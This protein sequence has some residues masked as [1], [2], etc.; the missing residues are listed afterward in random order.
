MPNPVL[1]ELFSDSKHKDIQNAEAEK[2][3]TSTADPGNTLQDSTDFETQNQSMIEQAIIASDSADKDTNAYKQLLNLVMQLRKVCTHPYQI[4]GAMPDPYYIGDHIMHASSKFIV[5]NK[6]IDE[7]VIQQRKQIII[8]SGFTRA[9][10]FCED[11]LLNKDAGHYGSPFQY[12]RFDG[13]TARARRNLQVRLFN[14]PESDYRVM[15]MPTRAGGLGLNLAAACSDVVFLDED[16]NPQVSLQ[17]ESRA[18]RIGQANPVTIW[19]FLCQGTVEE[20][21]MSRIRKKLYLSTKITDS[22]QDRHSSPKAG[23]KSDVDDS[24]AS[25]EDNTP[26]LGAS[27]L[28]SLI[29]RGAAT[30]VHPEIDVKDM[31][32]WSLSTIVQN[33]QDKPI[34]PDASS[35]TS[36]NTI[37]PDGN[38]NNDDITEEEWLSQM[39]RVETAVFDGVKYNR[40]KEEPDILPEI[41]TR[42]DRRVGKNTTVMVNGYA[43]AKNSMNCADW[44]AVPTL[45]GKDPRLAEPKREKAP[46]ITHQEHCQVCW[47]GGTLQTCSL[48]PRTYHQKCLPPNYQGKSKSVTKALFCPQTLL[49]WLRPEYHECRRPDVPLSLVPSGVLRGLHGLEWDEIARRDHPGVRSQ[50]VSGAATGV[51]YGV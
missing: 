11:L 18:H 48:C 3:E 2:Q 15:L 12:V 13:S 49:R 46:P 29:R 32:N 10:D 1:N 35:N 30:L 26:Q 5:L 24:L 8:F 42:A 20:Q 39:E 31:I 23:R 14:D 47:K 19:K 34:D 43:V 38:A 41:I 40:S 44:E 7:L 51:V 37:S 50:W 28:K 27:Q 25:V 45:A 21:M 6:L 36:N 17:A 4:K 16:W 9:L 22:M 33:C